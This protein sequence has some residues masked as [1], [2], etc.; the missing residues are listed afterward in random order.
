MAGDYFWFKA[1]KS[2]EPERAWAMNDGKYDLR[3]F[4]L[5]GDTMRLNKERCLVGED[6]ITLRDHAGLK[7]IFGVK[8]GSEETAIIVMGEPVSAPPPPQ[9]ASVQLAAPGSDV[10]ATFWS[11]AGVEPQPKLESALVKYYA[12]RVQLIR[13]P[14]DAQQLL[15][16]LQQLPYTATKA[17]L[18]SEHGL[19]VNGPFAAASP[20]RAALMMAFDRMGHP[21]LL[22]VPTTPQAAKHEAQ[23]WQTLAPSPTDE[24]RAIDACLVGPIVEVAFERGV[25]QYGGESRSARIG[26]V[27]PLFP[28]TLEQVPK[29]MRAPHLLAGLLQLLRAVCF[30]HEASLVHC[31]IKAP[32]VFISKHGWFLGD[33]GATTM[34]GDHVMERTPTHCVQDKDYDVAQPALDL[35][36][37]VVTSLEKLGSVRVSSGGAKLCYADLQVATQAVELPQLRAVLHAL[38]ECAVSL[39]QAPVVSNASAHTQSNVLAAIGDAEKFLASP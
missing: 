15:E 35:E 13:T 22:K 18:N 17:M 20:S 21:C 26:L 25:I 1:G 3:F 14:K 2:A 8:G 16:E 24:A 36:L 27:L 12:S 23:I 28:A 37:L 31:D 7:E 9:A 4:K 5:K 6:G 32:N 39:R 19:V 11:L 33:F 29:P 34:V 30:M 10:L 38:L